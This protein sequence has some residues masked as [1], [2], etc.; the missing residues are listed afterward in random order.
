MDDAKT[1]YE[2]GLDVCSSLSGSE[3]AG[4]AAAREMADVVRAF[5]RGLR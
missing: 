4:R 5:C 1:R 3:E 2:R